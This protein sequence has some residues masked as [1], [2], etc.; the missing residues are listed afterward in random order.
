MTT[1]RTRPTLQKLPS[2]KVH[3]GDAMSTHL[4]SSF[5]KKFRDILIFAVTLRYER[6]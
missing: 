4:V 6:L 3:E 1:V 2:K 5:K